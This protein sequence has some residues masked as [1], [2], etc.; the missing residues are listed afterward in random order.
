MT[1]SS[2]TY[3]FRSDGTAN[4]ARQK[5][6]RSK[7]FEFIAVDGEGAG[8]GKEHRYVLLGCGSEWIENVDGIGWKEAFEFLY[9]VFLRKPSACFVGFFLGYD[10]TQIIKTL[11]E[12]RARILLTDK[13]VNARKRRNSGG[14]NKPFPVRHDGWEFDM[15]PGRRLQIRPRTCQC[16]ERSI[17]ECSHPQSA[18]MYICD[19]G[20]FWQ[21]SLLTAINP[22][23]WTEPVV[24]DDEYRIVEAGKAQRSMDLD[25]YVRTRGDVIRY[26]QL[27][28]EILQRIMGK[29]REGFLEIGVN[30][31]KDQWYGPGQAAAAW[32]KS[33]GIPRREELEDRIPDDFW[34]AARQSYFG[35][36]FEIF[37]HGVIPGVSHEYDINSAYPY[38]IA[39]LPCLLHGRYASGDGSPSSAGHDKG[40]IVLVRARLHGNDSYIGAA[41]NRDK[42]GRIRRPRITEGWYWLHEILAGVKAG[43]IEHVD[44][45]EWK[46][47]QPC[48]CEPPV[49]GF[50]DLY[51]HRLAVG[52]DTVLGKSCKLVYNSG[53]GKFAQSTGSS[54]YGNWVYAS[55]ITAGCRVMILDAIASHPNGT[56]SVLMVATDAVF[57]DAPHNGLPTS[58]NLGA[59]D[60]TERENLTQFKPG[61]YWDDKAR[62]AIARG[63]ATA[64]KARGINARDFAQHLGQVDSLFLRAISPVPDFKWKLCESENFTSYAEKDWPWIAFHIGFS[65]VSAKTALA[66]GDWSQAGE[67]QTEI[68]AIQDSD[69]S[70]KRKGVYYDVSTNRLR[71]YPVDIPECEQ[72]SVPYDKRYGMDDP[73]SLES[74]EQLGIAPDGT[75]GDQMREYTRFLTGEE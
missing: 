38:I 7:D 53:Y 31:R 45:R 9:S 33:K 47:Y 2:T 1:S 17:R 59:W 65:L 66:R 43:V 52:K 50:R 18:W 19:A 44:Y 16:L 35:G 25:T 5:R 15:L 73:F 13:G 32:Y 64:F 42:H 39:D 71:T 55:L 68:T 27:E 61:V 48:D 21:C 26:N 62:R 49:R 63:S 51:Q 22:R 12:E 40:R 58:K 29:L 30:L 41:L 37:S 34:E 56:S 3:S 4:A 75:V 8:Y 36:W 14:N 57:F 69:P 11:P 74:R 70:D 46:S 20:P 23:N 6:Y 24:S 54:P 67:T 28:N 72:I 10:F 60:H